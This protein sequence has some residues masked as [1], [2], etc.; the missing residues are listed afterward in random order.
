LLVIKLLVALAQFAEVGEALS[1]S[2]FC[3]GKLSYDVSQAS[4]LFKSFPLE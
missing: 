1:G 2:R 4:A 3:N